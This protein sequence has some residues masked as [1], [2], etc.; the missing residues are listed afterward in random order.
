MLPEA[1]RREGHRYLAA[2]IGLQAGLAGVLRVDHIMAT[3]PLAK[4]S[5]DSFIDLAPRH[6]DR[7]SDHTFLVADFDI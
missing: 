3:V 7:P 6:M 1:S 5:V 2:S 4:T